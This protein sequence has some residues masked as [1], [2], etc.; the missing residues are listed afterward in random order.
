MQKL[1]NCTVEGA[2]QDPEK[3]SHTGTEGGTRGTEET[4]A[5]GDFLILFFWLVT[6]FSLLGAVI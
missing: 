1:F 5:V 4:K 3:Q 2:I 6:L